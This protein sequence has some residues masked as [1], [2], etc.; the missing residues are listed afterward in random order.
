MSKQCECN[1]CKGRVAA[2]RV[3]A[4]SPNR[5]RPFTRE[6]LQRAYD[7]MIRVREYGVTGDAPQTYATSNAYTVTWS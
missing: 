7:D 1:R 5:M 4:P 2:E 3:E 6:E